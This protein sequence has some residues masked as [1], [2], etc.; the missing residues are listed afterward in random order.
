VLVSDF[1]IS[2]SSGL[3]EN[4]KAKNHWFWFFGRKTTRMKE[5]LV[6]AISE[7][8]RPRIFMKEPAKNHRFIGVVLSILFLQVMVIYRNQFP[9]FLR[10][11][12]EGAKFTMINEIA[13]FAV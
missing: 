1:V 2:P 5:P 6:P 8:Q 4:F 3:F 10:A 12:A 13:A 11:T 9:D 7:T